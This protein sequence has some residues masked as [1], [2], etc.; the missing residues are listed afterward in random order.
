VVSI[1]G[2]DPQHIT[3]QDALK[4]LSIRKG[5]LAQGKFNIDSTKRHVLFE[6]FLDDYLETYSKPNK[7]SWDRDETSAKAL[8]RFFRGKALQQISGW[9]I[10]KYKI[11]RRNENTQYNRPP[12]VATVNRELALL[13]H[14]LGKAVREGIISTNPAK[15]VKLFPEKPNKLRVISRDEFSELFNEASDFL[16]PILNIAINTGM[17]RSEIL[18]LTWDDIDLV[19]RY[20]YVGDT[21]NNDYR[22][23]PINETLLETL[24]AIRKSNPNNYLFTNGNGEAVKSVKTAFWGA[25]RRSGIAHCRFHDLRHTFA[26]NLVMAGVDIVTVQELMGHK[27]IS[28]TRRYSHPTPEHKKQAVEKLNQVA[29]DTY[30]D[31]SYTSEPPKDNV[32]SLNH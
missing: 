19:K 16:K 7:K 11:H 30:L 5:E 29:I 21:K 26:T 15:E 23:I 2:V 4:A 18:N 24:K 27:D 32:T 17:R 9:L 20:I 25:L 14:M 31:T 28:M 10:E 22:I 13:K 8:L 1:K 6:V 12:S 3:R